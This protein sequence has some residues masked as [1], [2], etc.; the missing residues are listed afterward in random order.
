MAHF[1]DF[2]LLLSFPL[3]ELW[4]QPL[5]LVLSPRA[6]LPLFFLSPS[7]W[8]RVR[9]D[10]RMSVCV[11]CLQPV[12]AVA[13][14]LAEEMQRCSSVDAPVLWSADSACL[15][16]WGLSLDIWI[17]QMK[18]DASSLDC[19]GLACRTRIL[20]IYISLQWMLSKYSTELTWLCIRA[21][22][23]NDKWA[24]CSLLMTVWWTVCSLEVLNV[25]VNWYVFRPSD[26]PE[27]SFVPP[28]FDSTGSTFEVRESSSYR[29]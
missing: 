15:V 2:L 29:F 7:N 16:C 19:C 13:Y 12:W 18:G 26:D 22:T 6:S 28:E 8:E 4:M 3:L 24:V 23:S 25:A 27:G 1:T 21:V 9:C 17:M 20:L 14:I 10:V 5:S 11:S